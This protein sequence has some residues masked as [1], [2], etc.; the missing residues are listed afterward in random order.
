M[1]P[2]QMDH[3]L[4][5]LGIAQVRDKYPAQISGGQRQRA[6]IAQPAATTPAPLDG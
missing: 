3:W 5:R 2:D 6:A 4:R 1:S